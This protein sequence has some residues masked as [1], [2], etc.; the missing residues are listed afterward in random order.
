VGVFTTG[1]E[2]PFSVEGLETKPRSVTVDPE[3][4]ILLKSRRVAGH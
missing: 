1:P 2:T 4:V 3:H